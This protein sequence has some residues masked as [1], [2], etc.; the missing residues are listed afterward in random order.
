MR[1]IAGTS[2]GIPSYLM[3]TSIQT[4]GTVSSRVSCC[5]WSIP[6]GLPERRISYRASRLEPWSGGRRSFPCILCKSHSS[7][8]ECGKRF[9]AV[10]LHVGILKQVCVPCRRCICMATLLARTRGTSSS[11]AC[12]LA[13]SGVGKVDGMSCKRQRHTSLGADTHC[14]CW[15]PRRSIPA[16]AAACIG[17]IAKSKYQVAPADRLSTRARILSRRTLYA[18]RRCCFCPLEKPRRGT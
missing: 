7:C 5:I 15:T 13:A 8:S 14:K 16:H 11:L 12:L 18:N 9:P 17:C 6:C 3:P 2:S 4:L 1:C 10:S